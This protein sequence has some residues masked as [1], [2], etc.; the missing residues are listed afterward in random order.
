MASHSIERG[1][2]AGLDALG[3]APA[4]RPDLDAVL[5]GDEPQ[6]FPGLDQLVDGKPNRRRRVTLGDGLVNGGDAR[7]RLG[8]R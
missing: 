2:H 3:L 6:A 1:A 8:W 7:I 4:D 5:V